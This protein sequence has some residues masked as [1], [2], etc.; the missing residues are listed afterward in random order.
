MS[1]SSF[2]L[3]LSL[4]CFV[5][6][7][8]GECVH[9][10]Y[11]YDDGHDG[12]EHCCLVRVREKFCKATPITR[13]LLHLTKQ[14]SRFGGRKRDG[15]YLDQLTHRLSVE[16]MYENE[17]KIF[18][19]LQKPLNENILR[20]DLICLKANEQNQINFEKCYV[21]SAD[22]S[23]QE[24]ITHSRTMISFGEMMFDWNF[25]TTKSSCS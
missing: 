3:N 11:L 10:P 17:Q 9:Y 8:A 1:S 24:R 12:E 16:Q 14:C 21:E 18:I 2:L 7:L 6:I 13:S 25:R 22:N 20:N 5:L 23:T 4:T 19:H 15:D